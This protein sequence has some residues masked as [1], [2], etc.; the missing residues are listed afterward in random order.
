MHE[1]QETRFVPKGAVAFFIA[2]LILYAVIWIATYLV[3][4]VWR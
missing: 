2:M 3:M 1:T 4:V